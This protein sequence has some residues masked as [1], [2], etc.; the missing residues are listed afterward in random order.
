MH[1]STLQSNRKGKGRN[2]KPE[3][4]GSNSGAQNTYM[5]KAKLLARM[6]QEEDNGNRNGQPHPLTGATI[7]S[8]K[9]RSVIRNFMFLLKRIL[10]IYQMLSLTPIPLL[11]VEVSLG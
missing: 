6:S 5:N 2:S 7:D 11:M 3:P 10:F 9:R 8:P 4:K 1:P